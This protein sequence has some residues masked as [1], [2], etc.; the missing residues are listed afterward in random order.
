MPCGA[1]AGLGWP[2]LPSSEVW[3]VVV[4][5][6][7]PVTCGSLRGCAPVA[8]SGVR[9]VVMCRSFWGVPNEVWAVMGGW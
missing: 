4:C 5:P 3:A 6:R 9:A 8:S 1:L 2:K 7:L